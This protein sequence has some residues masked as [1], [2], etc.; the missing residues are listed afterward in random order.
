MADRPIIFSGPMVLALL[1]GRKTQTRRL[2]TSPLRRCEVGDRLW[3]RETFRHWSGSASGRTAC[4]VADGEWFDHGSGWRGNPK[5]ITWCSPAT[6]SIHMPRWASRLT[7]IVEEV[8]IEA[9]QA[10][11]EADARAEGMDEPYLGDGDH[12]F[13]EQAMMISSRQQYR[14]LWN[15]L[16]NKDGQRWDDNPQ[17]VA[18]NFRLV[19]KNI[20]KIET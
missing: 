4:Y 5:G 12:P 15:R 11:S 1:A 10:I 18:V 3:A 20:D 14:N 16:H 2:A 13:E 6:P 19:R 7:L 8:R 9:V 17:V